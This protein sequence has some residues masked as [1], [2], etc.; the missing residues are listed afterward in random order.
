ME[1]QKRSV[2]KAIIWNVI[3]L[4]SMS[5]VGLASTGSMALGGKMAVINA[6]LGLSCY[7]VYERL[8]AKVRWG[9]L[10]V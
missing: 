10:G 4:F 7:F 1:T 3:G 8:W 2:V 9:R 6:A 5:L